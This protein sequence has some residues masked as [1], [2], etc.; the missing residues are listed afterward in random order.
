[1]TRPGAI[2]GMLAGGLTDIF[3]FY[4]SGGIFDIY[5]IIP[6]FLAGSLVIIGVSLLTKPDPEMVEEFDRVKTAKL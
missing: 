3:W 2:A 6:G 5:E 4:N 1:M